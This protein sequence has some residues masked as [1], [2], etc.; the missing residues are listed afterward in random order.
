LLAEAEHGKPS[1]HVF[2][3]AP[4]HLS[5]SAI[6]LRERHLASQRESMELIA[7]RSIGANVSIGMGANT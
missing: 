5:D 6:W 3:K 2:S 7:N 4:H 1:R